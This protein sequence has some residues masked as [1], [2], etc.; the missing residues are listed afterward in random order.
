MGPGN[1][2][3]DT[4]L[5]QAEELGRLIAES[6]WILLTGG[7]E[8]GVMDA[9]SR[10]AG[11]AGGAVLGI[12]PGSTLDSCSK[13]VT[14]PVL[15]GMGSARNMINI[16]TSDVVIVCGMGLGTSSEA[17]L[18]IKEGKT[19]IFTRVSDSQFKFFEQLQN[20]KIYRKDE[21]SN[22]IQTIKKI[23]N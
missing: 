7:R 4:V 13:H 5:K 14:I 19:V 16:L 18:A 10:G 11:V 3:S 8:A 1:P 23:L 21:P 20:Q 2:D 15:T 12:L 22:V 9:A 17:A 6:G